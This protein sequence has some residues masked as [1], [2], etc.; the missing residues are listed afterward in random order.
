MNKMEICKYVPEVARKAVALRAPLYT[1]YEGKVRVATDTFCCPMSDMLT[2]PE[3]AVYNSNDMYEILWK[4]VL[5]SPLD[6]V[7]FLQDLPSSTAPDPINYIDEDLY[8]VE[9]SRWLDEASDAIT[10][11]CDAWDSGKIS[12][13]DLPEALGCDGEF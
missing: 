12:R 10:E 1:K 7:T 4:P 13:E 6:V 2:H 9:Y 5:D 11:F 3:I 8:V